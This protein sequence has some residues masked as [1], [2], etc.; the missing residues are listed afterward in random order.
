MQADEKDEAEIAPTTHPAPTAIASQQEEAR[1]MKKKPSDEQMDHTPSAATAKPKRKLVTGSENAE[2]TE[3]ALVAERRSIDKERAA[4]AAERAAID[5]ERQRFDLGW[6]MIEKGKGII[7]QELD[8]LVAE[9]Q[10]WEKEREREKQS[11]AKRKAE[12]D[13]QE[14]DKAATAGGGGGAAAANAAPP[15]GVEQIIEEEIQRAARDEIEKIR[16]AWVLSLADAEKGRM[17][18]ERIKAE[19]E[20]ERDRQL[21]EREDIDQERGLLERLK[22]NLIPAQQ[23]LIAAAAAAAAAAGGGGKG[24]GRQP[25]SL[26]GLLPH[27]PLP[28]Y[29]QPQHIQ[30]SPPPHKQQHAYQPHSSSSSSS[31]SSSQSPHHQQKQPQQ[32]QHAGGHHHPQ[33]HSSH[34]GQPQSH[35]SGA[36][37]QHQQPK[38]ESGS[39][40]EQHRQGAKRRRKEEDEHRTSSSSSSSSSSAAP[41]REKEEARSMDDD[42]DNEYGTAHPRKERRV[43][44]STQEG[45]Y[46]YSSDYVR[47]RTRRTWE[48][49]YEE[50]KQFQQK[51]GHLY[52][53]YSGNM[54]QL[55][56]WVSTQRKNHR[57]KSLKKDRFLLLDA[58]GFPWTGKRELLAAAKHTS[59]PPRSG[60]NSVAS[61]LSPAAD[62][63]SQPSSSLLSSLASL[64]HEER[65]RAKVPHSEDEDDGG[66]SDRDD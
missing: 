65:G 5:R 50:L 39:R 43:S 54:K 8:K 12:L 57:K 46:E 9:R 49:R 55:Y 11:L 58:L 16:G 18:I 26:H 32:Q 40:D 64:A 48:E 31:S 41:D 22:A 51:H 3:A 56:E 34:S 24:G 35:H 60:A 36:S 25:E 6:E 28:H 23:G 53:P 62:D 7:R 19:W 44:S 33:K 2:D 21:K 15:R 17:E 66:S 47:S 45:D 42:D 52:I 61:L 30:P 1:L 29:L 37:Q 63:V 20:K 59:S 38:G 4:I 10:A 13:A 14:S 27:V